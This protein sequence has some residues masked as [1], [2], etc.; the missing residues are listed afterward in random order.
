M[1]KGIKSEKRRVRNTRSIYHV[2]L[3]LKLGAIGNLVALYL[4]RTG[5]LTYS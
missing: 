5:Y 2:C 1:R 3:G 4:V